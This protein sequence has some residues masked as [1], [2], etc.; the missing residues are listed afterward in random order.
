MATRLDYGA[1][2]V[3]HGSLSRLRACAWSLRLSSRFP[4]GHCRKPSMSRAI[5]ML[6]T[7]ISPRAI[8]E[9]IRSIL[10]W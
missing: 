8:S 1:S 2:A 9:S 4:F 10:P 5:P 7:A 6:A 3:P